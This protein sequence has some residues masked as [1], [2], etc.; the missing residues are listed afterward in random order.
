MV[1]RYTTEQIIKRAIE[2]HG[3]KFGYD[4]FIFKTFNE[5]SLIYCP[6]HKDYFEQ[7]PNKHIL[8]GHGCPICWGNNKSITTEEFIKRSIEKW[9]D[10]TYKYNKTK[11]EKTAIKITLFCIKHNE[12]FDQRPL[13]HLNG[14][15][16]CK[17]C[18]AE[19]RMKT[20]EWF[21]KEARRIH[22][23]LTVD[24]NFII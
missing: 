23:Q 9:G 13:P 24:I 18:A 20:D 14:E 5:K 11:F 17:K 6:D 8:V 15:Q 19:A 4:K 21:I 16:G 10:E 7:T 3:N 2:V 12:Y 22:G 1:K